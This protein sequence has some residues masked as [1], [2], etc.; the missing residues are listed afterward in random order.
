MCSFQPALNGSFFGVDDWFLNVKTN[1]SQKVQNPLRKMLSLHR[2][3]WH[4]KRLMLT[5]EHGAIGRTLAKFNQ[6]KR[7][8]RFLIMHRLRKIFNM[9]GSNNCERSEH[10]Q[11]LREAF[12]VQG[13]FCKLNMHNFRSFLSKFTEI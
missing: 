9:R 5:S 10:T 11:R 12:T 8:K 2:N 4:D 7:N 1:T 13:I 6:L 3:T